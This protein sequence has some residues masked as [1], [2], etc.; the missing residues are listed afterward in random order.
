MLSVATRKWSVRQS[1]LLQKKN[2]KS[3]RDVKGVN[4]GAA[5]LRLLVFF[6]SLPKIEK[7]IAVQ[8]NTEIII[9]FYT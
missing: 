7:Q 4:N 8:E 6:G 1:L 2:R 3:V 9:H 5:T